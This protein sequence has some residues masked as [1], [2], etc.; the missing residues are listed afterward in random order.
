[1][2]WRDFTWL[3]NPVWQCTWQNCDKPTPRVAFCY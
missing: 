2:T 1:M 3:R